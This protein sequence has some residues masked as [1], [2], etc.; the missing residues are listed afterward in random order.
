MKLHEL[1][2]SDSKASKRVG[3]GPGSTLGKTSGR[4]HKGQKARSGKKKSAV[5]EGGQLP[6]FRALP[7]RGFNNKPFQKDYAVINVEDLNIF[8]DGTV[9]TPELLVSAGVIKNLK[10]GVKILGRGSLDK[11]L[12]IQAHKFSKTAEEKI[13]D[14]K[15]QLEVI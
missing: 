6:L 14:S 7:K 4:G 8:E 13:R 1:I 2:K 11:N 10:D 3:R 9:V 15:S 5:F 12:K